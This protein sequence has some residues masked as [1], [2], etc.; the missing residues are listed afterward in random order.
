MIGVIQVFKLTIVWKDCL[1]Q[2]GFQDR[3]RTLELRCFSALCIKEP[4]NLSVKPGGRLWQA[5]V[6]ALMAVGLFATQLAASAQTDNDSRIGQLAVG[7][8]VNGRLEI[9]K[10]D[11]LRA[12]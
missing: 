1:I 6:S 11:I 4:M 12:V 10:V 8:N 5:R 9:F 3:G 2:R 7:R